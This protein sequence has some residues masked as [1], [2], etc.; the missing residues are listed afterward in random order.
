MYG[1]EAGATQVK[2]QSEYFLLTFDP[3]HAVW[4][5]CIHLLKCFSRH[6]LTLME[7]QP[8]THSYTEDVGLE[9]I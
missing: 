9:A 2:T 7:T 1:N 6:H 3:P 8:F 5:D 4:H